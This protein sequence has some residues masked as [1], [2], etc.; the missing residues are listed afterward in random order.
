MNDPILGARLDA[1]ER[2]LRRAEQPSSSKGVFVALNVRADV[3]A[4]LDR[5]IGDRVRKLLQKINTIREAD[6]AGEAWAEFHKTAAESQE[7]FR[8]SLEILG[9]LAFRDKQLD[10]RICPIADELIRDCATILGRVP[11]LAIPAPEEAF[12]MTMSRI[13][14]LPFPEWTIWTLPFVAHEYG[15]V[16]LAEIVNV[17]DGLSELTETK[18]LAHI[19][20]L[21]SDAFATWVMGPAYACAAVV[22]RFDP[23]RPEDARHP[24]HVKRA[25]VVLGVLERMSEKSPAKPYQQVIDYSRKAWKEM[26]SRT[27]APAGHGADPANV[28]NLID[29]MWTK[30]DVGVLPALY[31]RTG[32]VGWTAA[33]RWADEW[34]VSFA[35]HKDLDS[36]VPAGSKVRDA[37]NAAW[38]CRIAHEG[39]VKDIERAALTLCERISNEKWDKAQKRRIHSRIGEPLSSSKY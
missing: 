11:S 14:R 12:S 1:L 8:E 15:H 19:R 22:L 6:D 7:V 13:V 18:C 36:K 33:S 37:L 17:A 21:L 29:A 28:E 5:E 26:V 32:Q 3:W 9:G 34:G 27:A 31:P 35:N 25:A 16:A 4:I 10:E 2:N 23:A 20:V 30:V 24:A 38:L 39:K